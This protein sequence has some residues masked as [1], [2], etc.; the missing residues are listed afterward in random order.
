MSHHINTLPKITKLFASNMCD[1][2]KLQNT[3]TALQNN[4]EVNHGK[5]KKVIDLIKE[6]Q[7]EMK[8]KTDEDYSCMNNSDLKK[9]EEVCLT[10]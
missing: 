8:K 2:E 9:E 10:S 7:N 1:I 4:A 5:M 3:V 6:I